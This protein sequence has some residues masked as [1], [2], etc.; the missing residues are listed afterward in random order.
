[1]L[2]APAGARAD[3]WG[4]ADNTARVQLQK[5]TVVVPAR[6]TVRVSVPFAAGAWLVEATRASDRIAGAAAVLEVLA[7]AFWRVV[8]S[9]ALR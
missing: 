3:A 4:C 5:D 8:F 6:G 7:A 9:A 1:M 2:A